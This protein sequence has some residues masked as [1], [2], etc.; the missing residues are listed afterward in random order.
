MCVSLGSGDLFII[1]ARDDAA[2]HAGG[3]D[4]IGG[5]FLLHQSDE[6]DIDGFV[7]HRQIDHLTAYHAEYARFFR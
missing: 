3:F 7:L 2:H 5:L 4:Q 1:R 6:L